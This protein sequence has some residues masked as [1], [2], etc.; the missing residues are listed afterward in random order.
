[1]CLHFQQFIKF[2]KISRNKVEKRASSNLGCVSPQQ[3]IFDDFNKKEQ[4]LMEAQT[5]RQTNRNKTKRTENPENRQINIRT[6][7]RTYVNVDRLPNLQRDYQTKRQI[8]KQTHRQTAKQTM[9]L[10]SQKKM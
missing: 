1:M 3:K 4:S 7:I 9:E 6:N 5:D 8:D 2:D 10:S